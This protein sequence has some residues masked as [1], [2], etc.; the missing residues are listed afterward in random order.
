MSTIL[1][2]WKGSS[3]SKQVLN[4][5]LPE[6]YISIKISMDNYDG[7]VYPRERVQNICGSLKL[8]I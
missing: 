4:T 6:D 2:Q 8:I 3:L 1:N 5:Q 7:L